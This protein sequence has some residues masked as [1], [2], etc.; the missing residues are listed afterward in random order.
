MPPLLESYEVRHPRVS[1]DLEGALVL[2]LT[3]FHLRGPWQRNAHLVRMIR[4]V[5]SGR[6]HPDLVCL[7]GDYVERRG[8]EDE[9]TDLLVRLARA[10]Q[11][12]LG[13]YGIFGNH[14]P[15]ELIEQV[16]SIPGICW[17]ENRAVRLGEL[18]V[19]GVSEP[20]D[21][22]EAMLSFGA[23]DRP[24]STSSADGDRPFRLGLAH[25][26][27]NV[28]PAAAMGVDL[29]LAG[30]THGGQIRLS[31][32][33]VPH[34]S[35]DLSSATGSGMLRLG[36]TLCCISRGLGETVLPIRFRCPRQVSVY[37]LSQG[38]LIGDWTGIRRVR[39]W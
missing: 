20:E 36:Q 4:L 38:P 19:V 27:T 25:Y 28:V 30:H 23:G 26:P 24:D 11:P 10:V 18:E 32:R 37:R 29:L 34:T 9:A 2:H 15:P 16:R 6:V 7:T 17:L 1:P 22:I 3:D 39:A 12:R 21:M 13:I 35:C 8:F 5:E 31:A 33:C 14:D